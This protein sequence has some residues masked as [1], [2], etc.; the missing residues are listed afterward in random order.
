MSA[1][2][3]DAKNY[4][5]FCDYLEKQCGIVL[6]ANKQY[7]VRSR[8]TPL[9]AKHS[10]DSL[11]T[12]LAKFTRG[13]DRQLNAAVIDAMTTNETLWFRDTYP[14]EILKNQLLN[15][16]T[17]RRTPVRIW[18]AACSSGQEPYS[19]AMTIHEYMQA[20]PGAFP[21]GVQIIGT[22]ISSDMLERCRRAEYNN[23]SLG[24]GLSAERRA[25]FFENADNGEMRVIK[26]VRDLVSFKPINLLESYSSLGK[27]DLVFCRNVLIYFS[28]EI[29][30]R[31]LQ[32]IA[33]GLQPG[34]ILMVGAS[35]SMTGLSDKFNL[36]RCS[37]GMYYSKKQ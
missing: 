11:S 3:F 2:D 23:L 17:G 8:L 32:Q 10:L 34:G 24:R 25:K 26:P 14:F 12:L 27:F 30:T 9:V 6:G 20:K 4:K 19:I 13:M 37:P 16:F 36:H 21:G 28:A 5:E 31:I 15:N 33:A 7:L 22:D 18:S 35:E 1:N 29:K